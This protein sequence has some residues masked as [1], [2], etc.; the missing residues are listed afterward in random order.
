MRRKALFGSATVL[1][2]VLALPLGCNDTRRNPDVCHSEPCEPGFVCNAQKQCVLPDAGAEGGRPDG[3]AADAGDGAVDGDATSG[4][5]GA[6][7]DALDEALDDVS[8]DAATIDATVDAATTADS[9]L[10][11]SS[12]AYGVAD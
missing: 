7:P 5:D 8:L 1:G 10:D 9:A 12:S 6:A 3:S 11:V 2:A 4:P